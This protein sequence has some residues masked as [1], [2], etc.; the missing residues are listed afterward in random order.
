MAE[1]NLRI[2][3]SLAWGVKEIR[4][5]GKWIAVFLGDFVQ[6]SVIDA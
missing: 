4:D 6:S 2:D 1:I 5:K 3:L